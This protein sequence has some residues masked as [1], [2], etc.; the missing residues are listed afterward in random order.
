M[1]ISSSCLRKILGD[2]DQAH[3]GP[4]KAKYLNFRERYIQALGAYLAAIRA[5]ARQKSR[6]FIQRL[7]PDAAL[8]KSDD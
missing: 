8:H 6:A 2:L 3:Q 4:E 1:T 5:G 7:L